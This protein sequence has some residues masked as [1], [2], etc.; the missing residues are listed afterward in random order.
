MATANDVL[1]VAKNWL[2]LNEKDGS[3]M[4]ILNVYNAHKPLARGYKMKQKDEWCDCFVSAVAIK[5][6]ATDLIGTE[7]GCE[8]HVNIFKALG[9]WIEDGTKIPSPGWIIVYN[10]GQSMQP[11]DGWSDHIGYVEYADQQK[12]ICIEGNKDE[13]VTR[14]E[15]P[16]GWGFIRGYA[17]P[18]YTPDIQSGIDFSSLTDVEIDALIARMLARMN[19]LPPSK[20]AIEA[21]QKGVKKGC[22][23][24][25]DKDEQMDS[26]AA[27]M[28]R[29][30]LAVTLDRLGLF[31]K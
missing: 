1:T 6:G 29:Q 10:W 11:N 2:G 24:D 14:R 21:V 25:G 26:P 23:S 20:Y 19:E 8:E 15:I 4:E 16:V 31:E 7:V 28:R 22:F 30:D 3:F 5:A 17:A 9:I 18:K 13:A 27:F 12:I